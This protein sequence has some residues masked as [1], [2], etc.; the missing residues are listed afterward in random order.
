MCLTAKFDHEDRIFLRRVV[1][2]RFIVA[3]A[4]AE[5]VSRAEQAAEK[6][7]TSEYASSNG[8]VAVGSESS[9]CIQSKKPLPA[10]CP[11]LPCD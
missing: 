3:S 4:R 9:R 8:V 2:G 7:V 10:K 6:S 1:F 11:L 5:L